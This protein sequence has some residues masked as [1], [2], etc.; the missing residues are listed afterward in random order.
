MSG[1]T[2]LMPTRSNGTD[3]RASAAWVPGPLCPGVT[4]NCGTLRNIA[5]PGPVKP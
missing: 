3:T 1:P 5:G 2:M 4:G